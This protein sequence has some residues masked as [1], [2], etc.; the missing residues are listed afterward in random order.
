MAFLL[1]QLI[2]KRDFSVL[3]TDNDTV[4][5]TLFCRNVSKKSY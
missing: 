4:L 2:D 5:E 3:L 1:D